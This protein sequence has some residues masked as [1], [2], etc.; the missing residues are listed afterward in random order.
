M[1]H[2][3]DRH[4]Q[5]RWFG[6]LGIDDV[7]LVGGKNASL[8]EM[9]RALVPLGVRI[10]DG[11]AVTAEAYRTFLTHGRLKDRISEFLHGLDTGNLEDLRR[12]GHAIRHAILAAD[13]PE[14]LEQALIASYDRLADPPGSLPDVAVRSSATAEDLPDASFAGQQETFLNVQGHR[15]LLDACKRCF[16]SLYTDRAISYRVDK[17]YA[18]KDVALSVGVQ[19]MVRADLAA[20]GVMFSIDTETGFPDAVLINA[21]YGLGENVVQG[22]INPDEFYVFKPTLKQGCRPILQKTLGSKEFKLIYDVGGTRMTR[23][24]PVPPDDRGRF[25]IDDDDILTL[26]RW[27][28]IIEDHYSAKRGRPTPMDMEWAK[29]GRTGELFIV[30]ARPETVQSQKQTDALEVYHLKLQGHILATGRSVGEK[31]G[32]GPARVVKDAHQLHEFR[33]GEVLV[34]DK[35]DPDWEPTMKKAAAIVTNRG[36]RTCHAAIVSRELGLPAIVGTSN[37]TKMV[38]DGQEVTVSCAE[39]EVGRVFEGLL[40]FEVRHID[41]E[42]LKR[43]RTKVMMNVGNP[44]EAFRLSMIPNDGVGLARLEF[45]IA[46]AIKVH[47][48]ALLEYDWQEPDVKTQIDRLTAGYDE[49]PRFF[50]DRLAQGVAMIASAFYPKDVI[51]RLSDFKTNEYADLIGGRAY[52]PHEENP[53]LGFRGASRYYDPRYRDGFA[54]ECRAMRKVRD[55]MGLTNLKLM[56][57]FC[58]TVEEGRKVIAELARHGLV[59]GEQGLEVYVMCEIPSNVILA[60]QFAEIFDGFS[61]GSN[62]LTQL[63]LGVDRD[64]EIVAH[65][66]DERDEAVMTM[67]ARVIRAARDRGRKIGI[68][69]QAPS[70][71]PEFARFLVD[72][73][74]DSISLNPDAVLK[75]TVTILEAEASQAD[76]AASSPIPAIS[77]T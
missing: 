38:R 37:G 69:G 70:D 68:C 54:L 4:P 8:G 46:N 77:A 6:E 71:Y 48:V 25:S 5:I 41:L 3:T 16:A 19:R 47:P 27:A 55:E 53:M 67:I 42:E 23:N 11:F 52:E 22:S 75:T 26:A 17:G 34:T 73:G 7:P 9:Y 72:Q 2:D 29:D 61:I 15:A 66:F 63:T 49:K 30:Q 65:L 12:R 56:I 45:I 76:R 39:G 21:A 36:G 18:D 35:T 10:P 60:E 33:D 58:R 62:D 64:S 51:V 57:P 14:D 32:Q 31:I 43:P 40:P 28:C 74:I 59:Q 24:V 44:E 13:L 50:V 20:S 1:A